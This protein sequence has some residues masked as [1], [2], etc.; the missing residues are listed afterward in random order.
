MKVLFRLFCCFFELKVDLGKSNLWTISTQLNGCGTTMTM[1]DGTLT[2][3][4]KL[5]VDTFR[6]GVILKINIR[7]NFSRSTKLALN[8]YT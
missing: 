1:N 5:S 6:I 3:A 4:N 7:L 2:F 8:C